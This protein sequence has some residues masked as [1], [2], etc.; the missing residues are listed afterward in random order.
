MLHADSKQGEVHLCCNAAAALGPSGELSCL[1]SPGAVALHKV[2]AAL[3]SPVVPEVY[4]LLQV[5]IL[6]VRL[7]VVLDTMRNAAHSSAL[8]S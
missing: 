1:T 4:L 8:V 3:A 6:A 5:S 2:A 7:L